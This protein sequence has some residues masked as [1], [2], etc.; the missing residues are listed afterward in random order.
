MAKEPKEKTSVEQEAIR[1][2]AQLLNETG[3]SEIEIEKAGLR[4]RVA[5]NL[6]VSASAMAGIPAGGVAVGSG[7]APVMAPA[8]DP[9]LDSITTTPDIMFSA[10]DQPTRPLICTSGPSPRPTPK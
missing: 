9:A 2:L 8:N 4:I 1:E 5:R 10:T 3:L 6:I 7:G